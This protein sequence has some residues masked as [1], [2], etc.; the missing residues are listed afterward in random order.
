MKCPK[1]GYLGFEQVSRCR[2]CGYDFAL[3]EP[4]LPDLSIR[5]GPPPEA[6]PDDLTLGEGRSTGTDLPLFPRPGAVSPRTPRATPNPTPRSPLSVRRA[7]PDVPR[8]RP[9]PARAPL[10]DLEPPAIT[11]PAPSPRSIPRA[12]AP[13]R[14]AAVPD[15]AEPAGLLRRCVASAV[16]VI[17]LTAIDVVVVYFTLKICGLTFAEWATLPKGPLLAFLMMQNGGY[18]VVFTAGGQTLG[19]MAAGIRV[20]SADDGA[21]LDLGRS[22]IRAGIWAMCALPAGLGFLSLFGQGHRGFH[23][24]FAGTR[25]IKAGAQ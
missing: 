24:Q 21:P 9:E 20:V 15:A 23:D 8:G 25:V 6:S 11:V 12:S 16:D 17:L 14:R 10:L 1:C 4:E 19:K 5:S 22:A 3:S 13:D 18:L 7:T 2:H